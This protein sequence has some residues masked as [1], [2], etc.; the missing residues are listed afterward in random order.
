MGQAHGRGKRTSD[1]LRPYST[2]AFGG[3]MELKQNDHE[4]KML[5]TANDSSRRCA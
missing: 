1:A 4:D 3:N 5:S 2:L